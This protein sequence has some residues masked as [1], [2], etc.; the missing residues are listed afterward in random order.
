M[1][2]SLAAHPLFNLPG[3]SLQLLDC[4]G[5]LQVGGGEHDALALA[6]QVAG[7]FAAG[8]RLPA[9][10]QAA[11]H[12]DRRRWR[13]EHDARLHRSHQVDQPLVNDADHLLAR[14]EAL[15]HLRAQG[16]FKYAVTEGLDDVVVHVGFE[17]RGANLAHRLGHVGLGDAAAAGQF[18]ERLVKPFAKCC[19]HQCLT[20]VSGKNM[21]REEIIARRGLR[22]G[23][24]KST[25]FFE[26]LAAPCESM[27]R[28]LVVA[29]SE[30]RIGRPRRP[31]DRAY[32]TPGP[33][34]PVKG[35]TTRFGPSPKRATQYVRKTQ[36][37]HSPVAPTPSQAD[38]RGCAD[39]QRPHK[40]AF[41][42]QPRCVVYIE[43]VRRS[44]TDA[45][46]PD[47]PLE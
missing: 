20:P 17:Q 8:R 34:G 38:L 25:T 40:D 39:A 19:E 24:P 46:V 35:E 26:P 37:R 43:Y 41:A 29:R 45:Q 6:T 5:S 12:D 16:I 15:G 13:D 28:R 32:S 22:H 21:T 10:L 1:H 9:S 3:D 27:H 44:V 30:G 42:G 33:G 31:S 36:Y 2:R 4:R 11:H 23:C 14:L 7:E 47:P 18:L